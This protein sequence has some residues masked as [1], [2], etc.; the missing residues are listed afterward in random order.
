[1]KLLFSFLVLQIVFGFSWHAHAD[2]DLFGPS[3]GIV[4]AKQ[5]NAILDQLDYRDMIIAVG[6][7]GT[8][9]M[10]CETVKGIV[11]AA[12]TVNVVI[13]PVMLALKAPGVGP[14]LAAELATMGLTLA[15]PAVLGVTVLGAF[16]YVTV[17]FVLKK[18]VEDCDNARVKELVNIQIEERLNIRNTLPITIKK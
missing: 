10:S 11:G 3:C 2:D 17:Y 12:Q 5:K 18:T 13:M 7:N 14:E 8:M 15:N 16:G 4:D 1:M 9:G 6:Q